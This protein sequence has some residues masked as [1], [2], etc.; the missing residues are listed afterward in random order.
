MIWDSGTGLISEQD[1]EKNSLAK[2][3]ITPVEFKESTKM[4]IC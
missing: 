3:W 4:P 1:E 2:K